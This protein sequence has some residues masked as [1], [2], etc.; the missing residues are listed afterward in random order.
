MSDENKRVSLS[1]MNAIA[2]LIVTI[3][4]IVGAQW[5]AISFYVDVN[6]NALNDGFGRVV[7]SVDKLAESQQTIKDKN[8]IRDQETLRI[9]LNVENNTRRISNLE[10]IPR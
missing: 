6:I 8:N 10:A 1:N 5:G 9:K 4:I 2:G 3:L 7:K